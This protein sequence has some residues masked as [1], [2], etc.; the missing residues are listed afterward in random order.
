MFDI[1]THNNRIVFSKR[2][3]SL[4]IIEYCSKSKADSSEKSFLYLMLFLIY[5][6]LFKALNYFHFEKKKL[7][8]N[9]TKKM[10]F[11]FKSFLFIKRKIDF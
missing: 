9:Y 4:Y 2:N 10:Q 8:A 7:E 5:S 6:Y 3:I 11:F 1:N